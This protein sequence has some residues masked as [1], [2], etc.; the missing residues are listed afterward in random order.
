MA[1]PKRQCVN[2]TA[3]LDA[4]EE[5][6]LTHEEVVQ[7]LDSTS[8]L[9]NLHSITNFEGKNL[10]HL[11]CCRMTLDTVRLLIENYGFDVSVKDNDGNTALHEAARCLNVDTVKYLISLSEC[12]V[13]AQDS[14]GN[15]A[16][17][18][19]MESSHWAVG[20]V[21]LTSPKLRVPME[22]KAGETPVALLNMQ[23]GSPERKKMKKELMNHTSM[24][25][26]KL[27]GQEL[28]VLRQTLKREGRR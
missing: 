12:D 18:A 23:L 21:L 8:G 4:F 9:I 11:A 14:E 1:E 7:H 2:E 5:G 27:E 22:N 15:T 19:A 25:H 16:L 28:T 10:L 20:K 3:I 24:K 6:L 13:N 17:H 26:Q